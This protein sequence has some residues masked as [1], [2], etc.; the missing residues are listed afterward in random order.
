MY[1]QSLLRRV[2]LP[3]QLE[4]GSKRTTDA[5]LFLEPRQ[6][7]DALVWT[8]AAGDNLWHTAGNWLNV[9]YGVVGIPNGLDDVT[10]DVPGSPTILFNSESGE[11]EVRSLVLRENLTLS[12]GSLTI[13]QTAHV[14]SALLSLSGGDIHGGTWNFASGGS[15][16]L[17]PAGG[18]LNN[19]ALNTELELGESATVLVSGTTTFTAARLTGGGANLRFAGGYTLSAPVTAEGPG[20]GTRTVQLVTSSLNAVTV[21]PSGSIRLLADTGGDLIIA[22]ITGGLVNNGHISMEAAGRALTLNPNSFTNNGTLSVSGGALNVTGTNWSN[23]GAITATASTV[24]FAGSW[25]SATGTLSV[26]AST[27]N[28]GGNFTTAGL[29][30]A[31]FAR[32][33]GTV[34][35]T[36]TLSNA[37]NTLT[38]NS[39]TGSWNLIGGAINGGEISFANGATLLTTSSGGTLRDLTVNGDLT[40]GAAASLTL[41]GNVGIAAVRLTGGNADLRFT[42]LTTF[43]GIVLAEGA[44][45]GTRYLTI[46]NNATMRL[47]A[48]G[49]LR[50][51]DGLGGNMTVR[52]SGGGRW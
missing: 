2:L 10:I 34:N 40:L 37:A 44:A 50:M 14:Q 43:T 36:G 18:T 51:A 48:D 12:G 22:P 7:L 3:E 52:M 30:L 20:E 39:S 32:A 41:G 42:T 33:G 35:L 17:T 31:G 49:E 4:V 29:N 21:A 26:S 47:S 27:L 5:I 9:D 6:L 13:R 38:L 23:A 28:L 19:S 45:A 11:R 24:T 16:S 8:G 15:I 46:N 1:F 25:S